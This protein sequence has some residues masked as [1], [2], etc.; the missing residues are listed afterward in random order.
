MNTGV[1]A[2]DPASFVAGILVIGFV[3]FLARWA[4]THTHTR[5]TETQQL[6][7]EHEREDR[8]RHEEVIRATTKLETQMGRFI[9]DIE[10][11]KRTRAEVNREIFS[12]LDR[13]NDR[14]PE[15]RDGPR[16]ERGR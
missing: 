5:I 4:W 13:I 12:K 7:Q 11:E 2:A 8:S 9:S 14:L 10:S 3:G 15:R 16:D 6:L 1:I